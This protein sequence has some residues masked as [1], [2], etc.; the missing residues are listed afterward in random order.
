MSTLIKKL[1]A[2]RDKAKEWTECTHRWGKWTMPDTVLAMLKDWEK[3]VSALLADHAKEGEPKKRPIRIGDGGDDRDLLIK[4][5]RE[6]LAKAR[7]APAAPDM[8]A[9][10]AGDGH[11]DEGPCVVCGHVFDAHN[12]GCVFAK[13]PGG[14]REAFIKLVRRVYAS[15]DLSLFDAAEEARESFSGDE[16]AQQAILE[17]EV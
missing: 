5:L 17:G 3:G 6:E 12:E 13:A 16:A 8:Q 1:E 15:S 10:I 4:T 9:I 2:L 7:P 14:L 11:P